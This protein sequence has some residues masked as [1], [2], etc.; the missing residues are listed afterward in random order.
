MK[1]SSDVS[2]TCKNRKSDVDSKK[3]VRSGA[4]GGLRTK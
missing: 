3:W 1:E 4:V 2:G